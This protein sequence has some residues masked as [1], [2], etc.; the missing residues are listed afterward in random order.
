[1]LLLLIDGHYAWHLYL[2]LDY[3]AFVLLFNVLYCTIFRIHIVLY[4]VYIIT[5]LWLWR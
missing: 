5:E 4:T 1:M 2:L 3:S